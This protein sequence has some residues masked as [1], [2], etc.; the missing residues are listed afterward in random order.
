MSSHLLV[1]IYIKYPLPLRKMKDIRLELAITINYEATGFWSKH[2]D[3]IS[4]AKLG[5]L[6]AQEA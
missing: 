3:P 6:R 4:A 1:R 5:G 2:F